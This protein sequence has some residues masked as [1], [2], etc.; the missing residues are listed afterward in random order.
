[1]IDILDIREDLH[2]QRE[3]PV[4]DVVKIMLERTEEKYLQVDLALQGH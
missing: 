2:T 3:K 4:E 1:M